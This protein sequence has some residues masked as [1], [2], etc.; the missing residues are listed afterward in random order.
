MPT[1]PTVPRR[2]FCVLSQ[3]LTGPKP[4]HQD[5]GH[6]RVDPLPEVEHIVPLI[7]RERVPEQFLTT[8]CQ[9]MVIGDRKCLTALAPTGR[10]RSM[11]TGASRVRIH[12]DGAS[13][14]MNTAAPFAYGT[15]MCVHYSYVAQLT[16]SS[17]ELRLGPTQFRSR[18]VRKFGCVPTAIASLEQHVKSGARLLFGERP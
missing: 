18:V 15:W 16:N 5:R 3:K 14:K 2:V 1:A 11:A 17:R 8:G 13:W 12:E 6:T 9:P 7:G 4:V 10:A